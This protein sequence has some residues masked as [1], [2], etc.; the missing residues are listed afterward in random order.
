MNTEILASFAS[1]LSHPFRLQYNPDFP[2]VAAVLDDFSVHCFSEVANIWQIDPRRPDL[3][4]NF[5]EF[6]FLLV[7][8]AWSG[9]SGRWRYMV[10]SNSG[11][12]PP[13]VKLVQECQ[14]R[15]IP[16]VFWNKED[17]PHFEEFIKT[18]SIFDFVFTSD[19]SMI[20]HYQERIPDVKVELL[21][22]AAAP[23]LHSPEQT[24]R[25]RQGDIAFAGQYFAHK[26]PERR[27]QM[28]T[29]FP[30]AA[31]YE[32]SIFSRALGGDERYQFPR[33]YANYVV[34]SL[35]YSEMV[36]EYR[37]HKIFLNV[38]SVTN[39]K[40]MCARRVFELGSCKTAVV[41]TY[42]DAIR[43]VYD[44]SEVLLSDE[45][46]G[47]AQIFSSL[48]SDD[49]Q[50]R[51]VVQKAWRKTLGG[52]TYAHRI[53]QIQSAIGKAVAQKKI[54]IN[55]YLRVLNAENV[56]NLLDDIA[57]QTFDDAAVVKISVTFLPGSSI[58]PKHAEDLLREAAVESGCHSAL[59]ESDI[60]VAYLT[61]D[62]R[63]GRYYFQDLIYTL[64]QQKCGFAAKILSNSLEEIR[65][66]EE[67]YSNRLPEYGWLME[68][69]NND[70]CHPFD[71]S[72]MMTEIDNLELGENLDCYI[73]DPFELTEPNNLRTLGMVFN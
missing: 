72:S 42:S 6:D 54:H 47:I 13:L 7:E 12:K 62:I 57:A 38:N 25:Y 37:R 44:E 69:R 19:S 45:P 48:L 24:T 66:V 51:T 68:T 28:D 14:K 31:E 15:G 16:T 73:S 46:A 63:I 41:G 52:H 11:P 18:A 49:L 29:L 50:R 8:S 23:S 33:P 10:T 64:R 3:D 40:T 2:N 70:G 61:S 35:P 4:L 39:S 59:E 67:Q 43:S 17:P 32:F 34:G 53:E 1:G 36:E 5:V 21:R 26:F 27:L 71:P 9:N 22:F 58:S 56:K 20:P 65:M 30:A 55:V 60:F